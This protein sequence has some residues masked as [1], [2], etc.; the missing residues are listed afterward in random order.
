MAELQKAQRFS[1]C[2][3]WRTC[4][5]GLLY[6]QEQGKMCL[7]ALTSVCKAKCYFGRLQLVAL[8]PKSNRPVKAWTWQ[9]M[10]FLIP[11]LLSPSHCLL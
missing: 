1:D 10:L 4:F 7:S 9:S 3:N 6:G 5:T 2:Q 8:A 11:P